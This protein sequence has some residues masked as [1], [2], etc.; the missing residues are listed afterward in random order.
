[1]AVKITITGFAGG[2]VEVKSLDDA[3]ELIQAEEYFRAIGEFVFRF[4]QLE[5]SIKL[6]LASYLKLKDDQ[7]DVVVGPYDFAMLCSVAERTIKLDFEA[8][9]YPILKSFFNKC[10]ALNQEVRVV[11]AHG[12][13]TT[14]GARYAS[15]SSL[16]A[17]MHFESPAKLAKA[18]AEA[19]K[20]TDEFRQL[21]AL[22]NS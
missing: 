17:K 4:S 2:P 5:Y 14:K 1:M 6:T 3:H 9:H 10:R 19:V 15:R 22:A 11:V 7:F 21:G 8:K 16:E 20:L 12:R 18:A 13:W